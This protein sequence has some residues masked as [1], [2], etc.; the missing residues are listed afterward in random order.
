ML[1]QVLHASLFPVRGSKSVNHLERSLEITLLAPVI[2]QQRLYTY[3]RVE[4]LIT[5]PIAT[6]AP[7]TGHPQRLAIIADMHVM[8]LKTSLLRSR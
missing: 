1:V 7:T 5:L 6:R 2:S 8:A 3:K 4:T